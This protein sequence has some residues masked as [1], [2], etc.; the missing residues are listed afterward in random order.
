MY[1][2][3]A[4]TGYSLPVFYFQTVPSAPLIFFPSV[5]SLPQTGAPNP[6]SEIG[7]L[8]FEEEMSKLKSNSCQNEQKD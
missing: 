3:H 8:G 1:P 2:F 7:N 5:G 4:M 6:K